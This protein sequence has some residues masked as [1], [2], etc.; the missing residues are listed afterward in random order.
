LKD[1][2]I[3]VVSHELRTPLASVYGGAVTLERRELDQATRERL[4][5][6]IRRES[7][8]LA[9][10]VD[11]VLW[12]SRLDAKRLTHGTQ[13]CDASAIAREVA[14][15]AAEM[16]PDNISV[17]AHTDGPLM[18]EVSDPEH[19][20]RVLANLVDNAIKYSPDGGAVEVAAERIDGRLRFTVKDEGIGVPQ[21]EQERI[22]EKFTR[23][24]PDM[25]R[26]IG[27]TGL[28]LYICRELVQQMNGEIWVSGNDGPGS[29][30]AF[31]IPAATTEG[32][33]R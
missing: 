19:V 27:G 20:R 26:G 6:I 18:A 22:F 10:L 24:D 14:S 32:V 33:G 1:E 4:F 25:T 28:G 16:A 31:E 30:F 7:A 3:A 13:R 5:G 15:T 12:A 9:K 17:V 11:D 8:R 21:S 2:F 23:L 29:T